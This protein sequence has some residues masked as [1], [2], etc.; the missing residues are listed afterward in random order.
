MDIFIEQIIKRDRTLRDRMIFALTII[1]TFAIPGT[2]LILALKNLIIHYFVVLGLFAFLMGIWAIWFVRSHQDSEYEYQ[3][4]QDTLVV[5]KIIAK[6]KRKELL[7]LDVHNIESLEKA[8]K[9]GDLRVVKVVEAVQNMNNDK[10]NTVAI[11]S[12]AGGG[13]RALFFCPNEKIL[14]AMKPYLKKDIVLKVFY[15]RG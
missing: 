7:R 3:M 5:S 13:K 9:V 8:D 2:V 10:D 15:H 12:F 11:Y 4:V 6:R 14:N 1:L